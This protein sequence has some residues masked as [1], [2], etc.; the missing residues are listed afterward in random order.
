[1]FFDSTKSFSDIGQY[2]L[3]LIFIWY[4]MI[5]SKQQTEIRVALLLQQISFPLGYN[6]N[7]KQTVLQLAVAPI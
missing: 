4:K 7:V 5:V 3:V 2:T 1:M 6:W